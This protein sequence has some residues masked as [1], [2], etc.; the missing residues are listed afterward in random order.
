MLFS[1]S[2]A[3]PI[4]AT[5][6]VLF[7]SGTISAQNNF[8]VY[9]RQVADDFMT[10]IALD[11]TP[12]S[13]LNGSPVPNTGNAKW[14]AREI[15]ELEGRAMIEFDDDDMQE[16]ERQ[17]D[18]DLLRYFSIQVVWGGAGTDILG[19][20]SEGNGLTFLDVGDLDDDTE[21]AALLEVYDNTWRARIVPVEDKQYQWADQIFDT[22]EVT[23]DTSVRRS[24]G[25]LFYTENVVDTGAEVLDFAVV[26]ATY[27][28]YR[29]RPY[30]SVT[31]VEGCQIYAEYTP[32]TNRFT[33]LVPSFGGGTFTLDRERSLSGE[34][35]KITNIGDLPNRGNRTNLID[36]NDFANFRIEFDIWY[37]QAEIVADNQVELRID[38]PDDPTVGITVNLGHFTGDRW[39]HVK[40]YPREAQLFR[41]G[42]YQ[43]NFNQ[44]ASGRASTW[45]LDNIKVIEETMRWEARAVA[46]DPWGDKQGEWTHAR[47][48]INSQNSGILFPE[49]GTEL[50][51]RGRA[52][53]PD[54]ALGKVK[55]KPKYAELGRVVFDENKDTTDA[56]VT[57]TTSASTTNAG[58]TTA[59]VTDAETNAQTW[60]ES[61][62][63]GEQ[64]IRIDMTALYNVVRPIT[65]AEIDWDGTNY[66]TSYVVE[67]STD[68]TTWIT[69]ATMENVTEGGWHTV[70]FEPTL[71]RYWRVLGITRAG[72]QFKI[73]KIKLFSTLEDPT[74]S[75]TTNVVG[76]TVEFTSTSTD[77]DGF[78]VAHIWQFGDGDQAFGPH[79]FHTYDET[80]LGYNVTLTVLDNHGNEA[81]ITTEVGV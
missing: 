18:L 9:F 31:P 68:G 41:S 70:N 11:G 32:G 45:W 14:E 38:D 5:V 65:R 63:A 24:K 23:D 4:D 56:A 6:S 13:D 8:T 28:E 19:L 76:A 57:R 75:F 59:A 73:Y 55:V 48:L 60:W 21:Y 39:H 47:D 30:K 52:L 43:L 46:D 58:S 29:N 37:P 27:A 66:A 74:A 72:T 26:S 79:V 1:V 81:I 77:L 42:V 51:V 22:G 50:Q 78:L 2:T 15:E 80:G 10:M 35:Y 20:D 25:R 54:V 64:W 17:L 44:P 49:R 62:G 16:L 53:H 40:L 61:N 69:Q 33:G 71:S 12:M 67:S 3:T 7:N 36:F 34:S